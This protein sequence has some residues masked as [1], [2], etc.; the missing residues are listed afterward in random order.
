L[1]NKKNLHFVYCFDANFNSQAYSSISSL[2]DNVSEKIVISIL[3]DDL[4]SIKNLPSYI[5]NH[6]R[7]E[8]LKIYQ[9]KETEFDFPNIEEAHVSK[10]TY[11]R[12]FINQYV[13]ITDDFIIYVDADMICISD[14]LD[15]IK[16]EISILES[17]NFPLAAKTEI[18]RNLSKQELEIY[19]QNSFFR[20]YWPFERLSIQDIYF[21]AGFMII[22]LKIWEQESIFEKLIECMYS[23][24]DKIVAWDQDVLNSVFDGNYLELSNKFNHFA[25]HYKIDE[26]QDILFLHYYGSKKPWTTAGIFDANSEFYHFNYR[27]VHN[28]KY[29]IKNNW[30]RF[31]VIQLIKNMYSFKILALKFP[32]TYIKEFLFSLLLKNKS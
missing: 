5:K 13:E 25:S 31:A 19:E 14:P 27:K 6:K 23:I 29:H 10:A 32:I 21:N 8:N 12:L 28:N 16:Q 15:S 2:L 26:E 30:R 11:F 17:E 4:N 24:K 7:L 22:N 18:K 3:H 20:K 9:F 1:I